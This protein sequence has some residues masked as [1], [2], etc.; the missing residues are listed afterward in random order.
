[1][2]G[3]RPPSSRLAGLITWRARQEERFWH[4]KSIMIAASRRLRGA[5]L[6]RHEIALV[7]ATGAIPHTIGMTK[8]KEGSAT[9]PCGVS[10]FLGAKV[11]L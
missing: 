10:Q 9:D 2:C 6:G 1:M 7:D 8:K 3:A 4:F 11:I 5:G